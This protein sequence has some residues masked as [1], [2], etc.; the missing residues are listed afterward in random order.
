MKLILSLMIFASITY[1]QINFEDYF[2][3]KTLRLDYFHT[4]NKD[5]DSYSFDELIEE[6][7][8]GGSK[9]NL[10]DKFNY[11]KYRFEVYDENSN[12]LIYSRGYATLFSE[13]QTT[14]EAKQTFKT[15]SETVIFPFPM[16]PVIVKFYGHNRKN[17]LLKKFEFRI[18]PENYFIKPERTAE[19]ENFEVIHS[20]DPAV[21]VD[22]VI[23][24][25]GYTKD[26]MDKFKNDCEKFAGYL[27][28]S[29]PFKENKNKFNIWGIAA[30]SVESGVDIPKENIWKKTLVNSNFYTFDTERYLMTSDNKTLRNVASNAPYDQIYILANTDKY[31]GGAIYNHYSLS[32][33]NDKNFEFIVTHEFGHGFASLADEYWTSDVA[34]QDFYPQ[35]VEPLDPNLTTLVDFNSKWKDLVKEGTPIPTP[36]TDEFK[37]K[38]GA[39]EGGGYM[40]KGI[41]RPMEDCTM[42]SIKVDGLC[43][44]CKRAIQQMIDFYSE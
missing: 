17:E 43:P 18:D 40:E 29:S 7:F 36:A 41:Y 24:P 19:Y 12:T 8:W 13:W 44:V 11:G 20:G 1:S 21:K 26:E 2:E 38:V 39:F 3:D 42:R 6:P 31:G 15:F 34:Y 22:I 28:N 14:E 33:T 32:V 5:N 9:V 37:N 35:D 10:V 16:K 27:F 25:E 4:G 30:P 23:I